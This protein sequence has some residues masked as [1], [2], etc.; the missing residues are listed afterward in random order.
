MNAF[1]VAGVTKTPVS[2]V[3]RGIWPFVITEIVVLAL[4]VSFPQLSLWVPAL[5]Y[6]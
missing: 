2:Q 3:F 4:L 6:K 1:V 5:V